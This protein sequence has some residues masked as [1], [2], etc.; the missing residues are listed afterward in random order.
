MITQKK[1]DT[2]VAFNNT[3]EKILKQ[4]KFNQR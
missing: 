4:K 2:V 3:F 1:G